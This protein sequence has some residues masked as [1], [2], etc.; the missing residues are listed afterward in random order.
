MHG[1]NG[2]KFTSTDL[3]SDFETCSSLRDTFFAS[4]AIA[5]SFSQYFNRLS[6]KIFY[7]LAFICIGR[8]AGEKRG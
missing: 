5:M 3:C 1:M 4:A 6:S 7:L 2:I 8:V